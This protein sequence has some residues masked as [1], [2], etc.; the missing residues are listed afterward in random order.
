M[1][2]KI[3]NIQVLRRIC[4]MLICMGSLQV[5]AELRL[6]GIIGQNMVLQRNSV[7]PIWGWAT[8]GAVIQIAFKGVTY[9]STT[10]ANG[11]WLIKLGSYSA[12]GPFEM[13]IQGDQSSIKLGNIIIGDVWLASGQSNMEFGIQTDRDGEDAIAKATDSMIH[14][15]FVPWHTSLQRKEDIAAAPDGSLNGKWII[16]TPSAMATRD[17]AWHGFSA[18]AYYFAQ[19]LRKNLGCP[20]GL[21]GSYKGATPAQAWLASMD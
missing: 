16:C 12:G 18:T 10:A 3:K 20:V 7:V 13:D 14:F 17:W 11:K 19:D 1:M 8:P 6:P 9:R 5:F 2:S 4:L 21:I 15:F